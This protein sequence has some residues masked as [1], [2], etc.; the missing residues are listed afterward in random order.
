MRTQLA[1]GM[2]SLASARL[3]AVIE[4]PSRPTVLMQRSVAHPGPATVDVSAD[5]RFVAFESA[6]SL[7]PD[8][9]NK[10]VDIYVLDRTTGRVTLESVTPEDALGH[11]TAHPRL[12]GDGRYLVFTGLLPDVP[13]RDEESLCSTGYPSGSRRGNDHAR[14]SHVRRHTSQRDERARGDQR[15][16][17]NHRL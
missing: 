17:P 11:W 8:D 7:V 12:S 14:L 5:G 4:E 2:L 3:V 13:P 16:R 9:R 10:S 15:R 1:F 6:V